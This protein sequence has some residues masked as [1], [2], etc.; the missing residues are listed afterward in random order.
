MPSDYEVFSSALKKVDECQEDSIREA[1]RMVS[2]FKSVVEAPVWLTP[3]LEWVTEAEEVRPRRSRAPQVR[4]GWRLHG[5]A[6]GTLR[7]LSRIVPSENGGKTWAVLSDDDP[8]EQICSN[9][10]LLPHRYCDPVAYIG[11][12]G[13]PQSPTHPNLL[14]QLRDHVDR[15]MNPHASILIPRPVVDDDP[16][17]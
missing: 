15:L 14:P 9:S 12:P 13:R 16:P 5:V 7:C 11:S 2:R 10:K 17:F 8:K 4:E 3:P 6:N 1:W